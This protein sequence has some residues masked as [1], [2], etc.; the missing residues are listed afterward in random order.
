MKA[1]VSASRELAPHCLHWTTLDLPEDQPGDGAMRGT[2]F[3]DLAAYGEIRHEV[4]DVLAQ[5]A[6]ARYEVWKRNGAKKLP[7]VRRHEVAFAINS[8]GR[9]RELGEGIDR[10]Y[11]DLDE[12]EIPGTLDVIGESRVIDFKTGRKYVDAESSFQMDFGSAATGATKKELHYINEDGRTTVDAADSD[13]A[14]SLERVAAVAAQIRDGETLPNPGDHCDHFYCPARGQ[15]SAYQRSIKPYQPPHTETHMSD[16]RMSLG[17]ITRGKVKRP[18]KMVVYGS[19]GAG[20]SEFGSQAPDP[21][22]LCAEDGTSQLDVARFPEPKT[23]ND[24]TGAVG[25]L[26]GEHSFKT[27]VVDSIDWIQPLLKRHICEKQNWEDAQYDDFGRGEK[28][29]LP[30]WKALMSELDSLRETKGMHIV[31]LAHSMIADF[32]NPE[33]EDFQR[34][35]LAL[36]PK[37]AELWKQW[38]DVLLFIGWE[39][40]TK[41]G[42]RS[43]KGVL[44]DRYLFTEKTAAWDAKNRYGLPQAILYPRH[45][46]WRAFADAVKATQP[47]PTK[48]TNT[49]EEK[50]A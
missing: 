43:V 17:A 26:K 48:P 24:V 9:V 10:D 41:K 50:A 11:G 34:Y 1:K 37:A 44:G 4:P 22:F 14:K 38:S 27:L 28:L 2:A 3:H 33:G 12:D 18:L 40:L 36:P 23:W 15:C 47:Q 19:E 21:I 30:L 29:A 39:T 6:S 46:G 16:N 8:H 13:P 25:E 35:Q 31:M 7:K 45:N 20:K 49:K 42:D 32:K 5:E